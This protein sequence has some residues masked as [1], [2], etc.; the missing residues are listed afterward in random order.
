MHCQPQRITMDERKLWD[1]V[2]NAKCQNELFETRLTT[3]HS[4]LI[5][6]LLQYKLL[7]PLLSCLSYLTLTLKSHLF[8]SYSVLSICIYPYYSILTIMISYC[9]YP[10]ILSPLLFSL[11]KQANRNSV[12]AYFGI[13]LAAPSLCRLMYCKFICSFFPKVFPTLENLQLGFCEVPTKF[14]EILAKSSSPWKS[15][16]VGPRWPWKIPR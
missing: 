7:K 5:W 12:G 15:W 16:L 3:Y 9:I 10:I 4:L 6:Q 13:N 8:V 14:I 11:V 2:I 1:I